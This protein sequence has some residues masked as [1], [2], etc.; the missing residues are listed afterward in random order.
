MSPTPETAAKLVALGF[1]S[2]DPDSDLRHFQACHVDQQ[3]APLIVDGVPGP[4]TR[5]AFDNPSGPAQSSNL[6]TFRYPTGLTPGR[7]ALL[8]FAIAERDAKVY[9]VPDGCNHGDGVDKYKEGLPHSLLTAAW[10]LIFDLW[11]LRKAGNVAA[12]GLFKEDPKMA[13]C[14]AFVSWA[15][16]HFYFWPADTDDPKAIIPGNGATIF[17]TPSTGHK[18]TIVAVSPDGQSFI[19]CEGNTGNGV[20]LRCRKRKEFVAFDN[21]WG[22]DEQPTGYERYPITGASVKVSDR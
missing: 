3:G 20:H 1:N 11:L 5:W 9:E 19:T 16:K 18:C 22:P 17:H 7:D 2:G 8:H 15:K 4:R 14:H 12:L 21:L 6:G 10:C 13:S